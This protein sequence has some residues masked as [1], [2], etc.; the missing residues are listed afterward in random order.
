MSQHL[1]S[2]RELDLF[3]IQKVIWYKKKKII[4]AG[5]IAI[6]WF[7]TI[8]P[9]GLVSSCTFFPLKAT[10]TLYNKIKLE[11]RLCVC[12][13]RILGMRWNHTPMMFLKWRKYSK[14]IEKNVYRRG[15]IASDTSLYVS[16]LG[17]WTLRTFQCHPR[18]W[19]S[20]YSGTSQEVGYIRHRVNVRSVKIWAS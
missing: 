3:L 9:A 13:I 18:H 10:F 17:F 15:E 1:E 7:F 2:V 20:H 16:V 5:Y 14:E 12:F 6:L 11:C 8:F 4:W 19:L